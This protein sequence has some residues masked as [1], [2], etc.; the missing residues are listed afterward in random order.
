MDYHS[1]PALEVDAVNGGYDEVCTHLKGVNGWW[2]VVSEKPQW[3]KDIGTEWVGLDRAMQG[4]TFLL[5]RF[6]C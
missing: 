1:P 5:R 2:W 3:E 4:T 6:S